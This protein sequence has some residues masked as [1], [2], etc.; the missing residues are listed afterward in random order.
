MLQRLHRAEKMGASGRAP[1]PRCGSQ[2]RLTWVTNMVR[3]PQAVIMQ[4]AKL[5]RTTLT[6]LAIIPEAAKS[7]HMDP[8]SPRKKPGWSI[9]IACAGITPDVARGDQGGRGASKGG[10][11]PAA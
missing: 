9:G 1:A 3:K 7:G 2:V 11:E 5:S 4:H 10:K 8:A 6:P